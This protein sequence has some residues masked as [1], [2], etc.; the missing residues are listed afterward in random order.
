MKTSITYFSDIAQK[1]LT[2]NVEVKRSALGDIYYVRKHK[3]GDK[4]VSISKKGTV[5]CSHLQ[6]KVPSFLGQLVRVGP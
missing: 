4:I 3:N 6:Q 1:E 2:M 5:V